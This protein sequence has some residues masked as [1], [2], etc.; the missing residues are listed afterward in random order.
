[1]HIKI[2][3]FLEN[4]FDFGSVYYTVPKPEIETQMSK[5]LKQGKSVGV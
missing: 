4:E 2:G 3:V 5:Q 1:M